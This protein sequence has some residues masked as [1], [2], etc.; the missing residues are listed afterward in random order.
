[1][2]NIPNGHVE[3]VLLKLCVGPI[4]GVDCAVT[5]YIAGNS[6]DKKKKI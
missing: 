6:F 5:V 4:S 1:M 3:F 2:L